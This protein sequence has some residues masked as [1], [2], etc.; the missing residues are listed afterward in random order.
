[1]YKR[2]I[3]IN[4]VAYQILYMLSADKPKTE[5]DAAVRRYSKENSPAILIQSGNGE[6]IV[7]RKIID[8]IFTDIE[9]SHETA[10]LPATTKKSG[11]SGGIDNKKEN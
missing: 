8:V 6:W 2:T 4:D 1:M 3:H 9:E 7:A 11:E 5:A 10:D